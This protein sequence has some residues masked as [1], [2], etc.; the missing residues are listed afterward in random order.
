MWRKKSLCIGFEVQHRSLSLASKGSCQQRQG[1]LAEMAV[2]LD[3]R[4]S[5]L[6]SSHLLKVAELFLL[7]Y[8]DFVYLAK[9]CPQQKL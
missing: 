9:T 4:I 6:P 3:I 5:V 7:K 1:L 8:G 2:N